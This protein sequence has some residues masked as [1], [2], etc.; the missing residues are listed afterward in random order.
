MLLTVKFASRSFSVSQSTFLRVLQNTTAWVM[1]KLHEVK[2]I[3][4]IVLAKSLTPQRSTYVSY[5][6]NKVSALKSSC[7]SSNPRQYTS[8]S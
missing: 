4:S 3:R 1:V 8:S 7:N 6:S 2:R 5:R